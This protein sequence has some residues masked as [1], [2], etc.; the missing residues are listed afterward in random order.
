MRGNPAAIGAAILKI[1]DAAEPPLR[2]FLGP[3]PL[4]IAKAD[5]ASRIETWEK[6]NDVSVAAQGD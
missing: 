2:I 1:V 6:W 5:Y 4:G 3:S